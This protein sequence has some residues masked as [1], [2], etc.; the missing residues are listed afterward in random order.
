M[1]AT[2]TMPHAVQRH[3]TQTQ[4]AAEAIARFG[5]D[6]LDWAFRC[7]A[8]S[9][10]QT[11]RDCLPGHRER[12]CTGCMGCGLVAEEVGPP[13][14]LADAL[15]IVQVPG[16]AW[17]SPCFPLADALDADTLPPGHSGPHGA[18]Q[19]FGATPGPARADVAS[20][21]VPALP[22]APQVEEAPGA[23]WSVENGWT[24]A[25]RVSCSCHVS[26]PCDQCQRLQICEHCPTEVS[27]LE[28]E[29]DEHLAD[30]HP[31]AEDAE[32]E[33]CS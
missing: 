5:P 22:R 4:L 14:A 29:M 3:L 25:P 19:D 13:S 17:P 31:E 18:S 7:P 24:D 10:V 23:Y 11:G 1:T 8:C 28:D 6:P 32:S 30:I 12:V 2:I 15:W 9:H 33:A 16:A 20:A 21:P 27:V 26:A